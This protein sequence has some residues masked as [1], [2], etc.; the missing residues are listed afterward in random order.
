MFNLKFAEKLKKLKFNLKNNLVTNNINNIININNNILGINKYDEFINNIK[1]EIIEVKKDIINQD[2]IKNNNNKSNNNSKINFD[3]KENKKEIK[4][5]NDYD[6]IYKDILDHF[7][8]EI[9]LKQKIIEKENIIEN[10]KN[11]TNEKEYLIINNSKDI[12]LPP[13]QKQLKEKK[14]EIDDK[15]NKLLKGYL[16]KVN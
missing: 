4:S 1:E 5:E 6:K 7:Q 9:K 2:K 15:R 11:E 12:N 16:N 8:L 10:L 14:E 13:L 3:L